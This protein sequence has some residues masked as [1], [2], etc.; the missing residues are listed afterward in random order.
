MTDAGFASPHHPH[1]TA[2]LQP[3]ISRV[4]ITTAGY[5]EMW[6]SEIRPRWCLGGVTPISNSVSFHLLGPVCQHS[7]H[8]PQAEARGLFMRYPV[9][10]STMNTP[11]MSPSTSLGFASSTSPVFTCQYCLPYL[12][13]RVPMKHNM[14]YLMHMKPF[15]LK[16]IKY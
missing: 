14:S 7:A 16:T 8:I 12:R 9:Q 13:H 15:F 6:C 10:H 5:G 2:K 4:V 3:K 1:T 11:P